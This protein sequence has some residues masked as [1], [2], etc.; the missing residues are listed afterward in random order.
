[1]NAR[2]FNIPIS[3]GERLFP[4]DLSRTNRSRRIGLL[5]YRKEAEDESGT[6]IESKIESE[7]KAD[8]Q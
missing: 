7:K 6:G 1:M 4:I 5:F 8:P 3:P 2:I